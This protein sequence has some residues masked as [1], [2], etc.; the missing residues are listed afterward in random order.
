[1]EISKRRLEIQERLKEA[2]LVGELEIEHFRDQFFRD[3]DQFFAEQ[4]NYIRAQE[5]LRKL[6]GWFE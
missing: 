6:M 2:G 5:D 4:D 3:Q 1:V